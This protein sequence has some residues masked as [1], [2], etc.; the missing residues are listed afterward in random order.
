[1]I[2]LSILIA[3][4]E[5]LTLMD[6]KEMVEEAGHKVCA[7]TTNGIDA[8]ESAK[9]HLPDLAILDIK[10]PGMNGIEVAKVF[11][12]LGIPVI[13]LTAYSQPNFISRAEKVHVY[14]YLVKPVTERDLL[15]AIQIAYSRCREMQQTQQELV[16]TQQE[17][18]DQK[19]VGHAQALLAAKNRISEIEA[20]QLLTKQAMCLQLP[21]VEMSKQVIAAE[22]K[23][24]KSMTL[25]E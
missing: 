6:I 8:I 25:N 13:L 15:P 21:L 19:L 16:K 2:P 23:T 3:E 20:R 12:Y 1:M 11:Y 14:N 22:K 9:D 17:L 10:M 4:D 7:Q 5:V 24:I 18:C